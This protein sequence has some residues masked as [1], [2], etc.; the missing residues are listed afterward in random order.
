MGL[1]IC[2]P[3][4]EVAK[5]QAELCRVYLE[6]VFKLAYDGDPKAGKVNMVTFQL[7]RPVTSGTGQ[8]SKQ[9]IQVNAPLMAL[10]PI[11]AFTMQEATVSFTMEVK[12]QTV[13]TSSTTASA[14]SSFGG[15]FWGFTASISGSVTTS[16]GNTRST[17]NSAKY[18]ISAKATQQPPRRACRA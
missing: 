17:D 4:I 13:D 8:I 15:S 7:E 16:S 14:G 2:S 11:P 9:Q 3:I 1:L 6:Y 10:V 5:G 18:D 12:E